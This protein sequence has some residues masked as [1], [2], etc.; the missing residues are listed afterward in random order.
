MT[1]SGQKPNSDEKAG[2]KDINL[3]ALDQIGHKTKGR[4]NRKPRSASSHTGVHKNVPRWCKR[5]E[6]VHAPIRKRLIAV[7]H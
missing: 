5:T 4:R 3:F 7:V 2:A 1:L 6:G